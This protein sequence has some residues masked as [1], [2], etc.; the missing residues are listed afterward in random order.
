MMWNG[1]TNATD[2]NG[3]HIAWHAEYFCG[4]FIRKNAQHFGFLCFNQNESPKLHKYSKTKA[5]QK[6]QKQKK[7]EKT[8]ENNCL[9][10]VLQA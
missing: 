10:S 5:K 8:T 4:Q 6:K 1:E 2:F 7:K 3:Y 9:H